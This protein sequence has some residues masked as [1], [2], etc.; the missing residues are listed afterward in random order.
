VK[1]SLRIVPILFLCLL[2]AVHTCAQSSPVIV[3]TRGYINGTPLTA[4]TS[5]A[6]NSVGASTLV[7]FVST[8][9]PWNGLPV[10]ITG[11]SDSAGN[12]WNVLTGPTTWA[13]NSFT[14]VSAIYYVNAPIPSATETVTVNLSNPA[15][16]VFHVFALSGADFTGP[17]ISSAITNPGAGGTSASVTTAP[18]TV[19]ADSLLLSW[20]K[21]ETSASAT[22]LD[23]YTPDAQQSTSFLWAESEAPLNA[24]SY[25]GQFQYDSAIGWQ[26]AVVGLKPFNGPQAASQSVT[27]N[28]NTPANITLTGISP[29]GFPL[30]YSVVTGPSV[31]ALSGIAPNLTYTP[32]P[33]YVGHDV[34]TFKVNDGT[35]DSNIATV[36]ITVQGPVNIVGSIGYINSTPLTTHT[37]AAFNSVGSSTL[38]AFVSSHPSWNGLPVS[39][40]GLSDGAGNTWSVVTGPTVWAGNSFTLLS[41]IYYVNSPITSAT[42]T[43][44]ASLSNPAPLV[45]HVFAVSG[46]DITG[47]PIFSAITNPAGGTSASVRTAPVALPANGLLLS[48]VKNE[49]SASA[50]AVGGYTLDAQQSTTFLWAEHETALSAGNY[51]GQFQYDSAIGWQTAIV[52]L[53]PPGSVVQPVLTATPANPTNQTSAN[54]AF[55]DTQTGVSF[56]CQLDGSAFSACTSPSSYSGLSQGSHTFSVIAVDASSNQSATVSFTWLISTTP[57]PAPTI[58]S[59]PANPTNQTGAS[60]SFTDTQAGVSFLCQLDGSALSACTSPSSYSGLSQGS[61]TFSVIAV[62]ASNTRSAP[63]SFAWTINTTPPP[64]P[65]I[66]ST[67]ANPTNQTS[68][69]FSFTDTQAGVSFLC[70]LDG[71]AF[72]ACTSPNAYAGLIQASHTFSV[73]AQDTAGNQSTAASFT[74]TINTTAPPTPTITAK[75]A[76]PTNLT[77]ASFSFTD[78]QTGVS[79]LCQLDGGV[80]SACTSPKSYSGLSLSS[81]TFSVKAQDTAGNQSGAASFTWTIQV[82]IITFGQV[83]AATPQ[84]STTT[85]SATFPRAQSAGNLNIV[86]VGWNDTTSSVQLVKDSAGNSYNLAIGPTSGTA[87]QQSIYYAAN[88][89]GGNNTVTVT[90]N[91]AAAFPDVRIL[92]YSGVTTLDVIAGASGNSATANSGAATITSAYELVFGANMVATVTKSAGNGF[93]S[94]IITSPDGDIAEDK[95]VTAAGSNSATAT[96]GSAGPWVMQMVTFSSSPGPAPTVSSVS[97]NT[98]STAGG[99]AVTI[100]GTNFVAG[101]TVTFGGTPATNVTVVLGTQITATTPAGSAGPVAAIVTNPGGQNGGLSNGFTY[102]ASPP[103]SSV[104][105][106][107]GPTTGGTPVTITGA[108][109]VAGATVTFG[110]AAATNVVV[111]SPTQITATTPAGTAGAV[112]VK[113]TNPSGL[114]GGLANGFMYG[115][116]TVSSVSPNNGPTAGGTAVTITG[117]RFLAGATVTFGTNAAT[118]VVVVSGTQITATTPAETAGPVAVT[119]TN[120][121]GLSG[122]L[123]NGFTYG[124]PTISSIS[125]NTGS[126]AGGTAVTIMG[127]NFATGATVTFGTSAATSV[128]VASATKISATTPA[129]TVGGVTVTVTN[130]GGQSGSLAN[131]FTYAVFPTVSSISPNS[132][133]AAGGTPVT[134]TGTNFASGATVTFGS[135]AATNIVV[136]SGTQITATTPAGSIG[137]VAVT[138]MIPGGQSGSLPNGYTY[139]SAVGISFGQVAAAT[140]QSAMATVAVTFPGAQTAGNLNIVVVGWNDTTSAVTSVKDSAGNIYSLAIGPTVGT[141]LQQS[142]YYASNI[143]GGSNKVTVTFN[144]AAAY[145]DI[146]ILE[147]HGVTTLDAIAGASGN[148]TAANS[149]SATTTSASELIFGANT[150][151]TLTGAAGTGFASRIITSDGD[152]AED[153]I[154]TAAG[155][156]SATATLNSSG[157]WVMQMVT[158]K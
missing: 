70:Q 116:P 58:T 104:S 54:F 112:T 69:S 108:N 31:G 3:S 24:G 44:T 142:I 67:P 28:F 79:F 118:N 158:F 7:A 94:R 73:K 152:I 99:T 123:T 148:S 150:V 39:I 63:A 147:Y 77:T 97:P 42:E 132:G 122:S 5:T 98:G 155:S 12:S 81:H 125:P 76:N 47:V 23:G 51:M 45:L 50:T 11:L 143:I 52:G 103:I 90:F 136:V 85:V 68:A 100:T 20:V 16:L 105:P 37:S 119:V 135:A 34:F 141:A 95:I 6:F 157:P 4:H 117:T 91:Q 32:A 89:V 21:N 22:A 124:S 59:M 115:P 36:S 129:G 154:V 138:V 19:P 126:T 145:P 156:N 55:T 35:T 14:L 109:F 102:V 106:N 84:S 18:I 140:P 72:S 113:V 43:V 151:F 137:A 33:G 38:V 128:V 29:Q 131:G 60:F 25:S 114:S 10:S 134:I 13:G 107:N 75:P 96:L 80:F 144:Q 27:T 92:E 82:V 2:A 93:T 149:G 110:T 133:P 56:L 48:W 86:V 65:T 15:P 46:A 130:V 66:T 64:V 17:P 9:T 49:T 78:T 71:A 111:V 87:L 88:I 1:S 139:Q 30:T 61:H 83:A 120:P 121:G 26:T 127:T 74:W 146:R 57:P 62:D 40:N 153:K 41:T 53:K 101:A 8:N